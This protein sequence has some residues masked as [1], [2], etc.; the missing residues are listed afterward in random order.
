MLGG[1]GSGVKLWHAPGPGGGTLSPGAST[2][3]LTAEDVNLASGATFAVELNGITAGTLYD[4]LDVTAGAF[5]LTLQGA[6]LS[7]SLGYAP[8]LG[9]SFE[10]V[11]GPNSGVFDGLANQA[12]FS[13]GAA[14]MRITYD[15]LS[16]ITL[17]V[18]PEPT[19]TG[20]LIAGALLLGSAR[21]RRA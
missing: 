9:D 21:R 16:D 6:T 8:A 19:V 20:L 1:H 13:A 17:T 7:V 11:K 4:Q 18:V 3:I 10:I 5:G 2:A 14:L 15:P 12:V